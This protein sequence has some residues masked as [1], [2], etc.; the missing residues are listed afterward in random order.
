MHRIAYISDP[1]LSTR[2]PVC[3]RDNLEEEQWKK[4]HFLY[5]TARKEGCKYVLISGD[6]VDVACSWSL[7]PQVASF[8]SYWADTI[9]TFVVYGQHDTNM[10]DVIGREK[11]I[12]GTLAASGFVKVLGEFPY[13][14]ELGEVTW[15]IYGASYGQ[16]V[17][18]VVDPEAL[19][20]LV[21]HAPICDQSL[22]EGMDHLDAKKFLDKYKDFELIITGDIHKPFF[23]SSGARAIVNTGPL[24]RRSTTEADHRPFFGIFDLVTLE[25]E[26]IEIPHSPS[27]DV[28]SFEHLDREERVRQIN[29]SISSPKINYTRPIEFKEVF[30]ETLRKNHKQVTP[31]V[32]SFL[33]KAT[34]FVDLL[35][36]FKGGGEHAR[37]QQTDHQETQ[38][39]SGQSS[40][41][42]SNPGERDTKGTGHAQKPVRVRGC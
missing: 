30:Q 10:Y 42:K 31:K 7:M 19:N 22:W 32:L 12:V 5:N 13:V 21:I 35:D 17:P 34:G 18:K 25:H 36:E 15:A 37:K 16:E 23:V 38:G 28:I 26:A 39:P 41:S 27:Q 29:S 6:L 40:D 1:H 3:R 2:N 14:L 20:I 24:L 9:K 4:L 33:C 8:F 11:T